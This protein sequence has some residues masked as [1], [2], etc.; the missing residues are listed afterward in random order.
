MRLL[1]ELKRRRVLHSASLYVVAAWIVLQVVEVL[2]GAGLPPATMRHVLVAMSIGFPFVLIISWFYDISGEGFRRSP[3]LPAGE[4]SPDLKLG[5]FALMTGLVAVVALNIY[6]LSSPPP[7]SAAP[8][9]RIEQRTLAVLSFDDIDADMNDDPV[10][11]AIAGELRS[12]LTRIPG[13][14]VLGP[15]TSRAIK[16]ADDEYSMASEIGVTVILTGDTQ[17]KD[18][19]LMLRARLLQLPA[20]NIVWQSEFQDTTSRA[21]E[22]QSRVV[23]AVLGTIIPNASAETPHA[24]RINPGECSEV[25]DLYLRAKQVRIAGDRQRSKELL[26]EAVQIDPNCAIAWEGI[27]AA[28]IDWSIEGFAKAGAAARRALELNDSLSKAWVVLAEIAEQESRWNEAEELYLRALYVDPTNAF[29]NA[30]YGE[31]LLARGRVREALHYSLEGYRYE[32]AWGWATSHV[33][34]AALYLGDAETVI[35]YARIT[36]D[37]WANRWS[38]GWDEIAEGYLLLGK[39]DKALAIYSKIDEVADWHLQCIRSREQPELRQGL[40][41]EMQD[42][43][44]RHRN[45]ELTG[46]SEYQIWHVVRCATWIGE[47]DLV[48]D[49]LSD[50]DVPNE[51]QFLPFF[52]AD[53]GIL[54]QTPYFRAKV[55]ESG[56]LD[57]WRKWGWSDYCRPDGDSFQCD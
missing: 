10:G 19:M 43:I 15:R 5:D 2:S 28:H 48:I 36:Q 47:V 39:V 52:M 31:A 1:R 26:Q 51:A 32:P 3:A 37:L 49:I 22:L 34:L 8:E 55:V 46:N 40:R 41:A 7:L 56:L 53:S 20:G 42:T 57:Y 21:V 54:R 38:N 30:F 9:A 16:D 25:Y 14:R 12:E 33:A 44:D 50:P 29:A 17:L 24:P 18:G 23:Q 27:A 13:L 35:K 11:A 45:G 4:E 6:V